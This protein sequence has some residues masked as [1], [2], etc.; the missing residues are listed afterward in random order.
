MTAICRSNSKRSGWGLVSY[1]IYSIYSSLLTGRFSFPALRHNIFS[2]LQSRQPFFLFLSS[3][4]GPV[5]GLD[6]SRWSRS[7]A[8]RT[9]KI[10]S[11][12]LG[13]RR[14]RAGEGFSGD[15]AKQQGNYSARTCTGIQY[16][17]A[18]APAGAFLRHNAQNPRQIT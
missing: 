3:V 16:S 2:L 1:P 15:S 11:S 13:K 4:G 10:Q 8:G 7:F 17:T 6:M 14:I 9:R 12:S 18:L 5:R